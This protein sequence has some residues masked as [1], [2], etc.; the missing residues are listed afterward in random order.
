[1]K[2]ETD[3]IS[4]IAANLIGLAGMLVRMYVLTFKADVTV[5]I[6]NVMRLTSH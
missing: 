1:M 4:S 2:V 6:G 3:I 5:F